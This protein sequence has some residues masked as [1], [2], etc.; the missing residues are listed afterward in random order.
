MSAIGE[1]GSSSSP[2]MP[3]G[4]SLS[5]PLACWFSRRLSTVHVRSPY[6]PLSCLPTLT[7]VGTPSPHGFGARLATMAPLSRAL[8]TTVLPRSHGPVEYQ[9]QNTGLC[10]R[11]LRHNKHISD[12]VSQPVENRACGRV[13]RQRVTSM[14]TFPT[15]PLRT[16]RDSFD[17]KQLS[18]GRHPLGSGS[19][20]S[21]TLPLS[22]AIRLSP[23]AT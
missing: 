1:T 22:H 18:S 5:A 19:C 21:R 17:V 12:F 10:P 9:W 15:A 2:H 8:H 4:S 16:D 23:F 3:F 11:I 13:G 6:H 20:A 7:L 14:G